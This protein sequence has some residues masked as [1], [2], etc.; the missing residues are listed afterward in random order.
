MLYHTVFDFPDRYQ[1]GAYYLEGSNPRLLRV[2]TNYIERNRETITRVRV[3]LYLL[4]NFELI[5]YL[6][7]LAARG[8]P[9]EI[10]SIPLEGYD[11]RNPMQLISWDA[12]KGKQGCLQAKKSYS[13]L[14][15]A[16]EVYESIEHCEHLIFPHVMIRSPRVRPF[17]RGILPFSLHIKSIL[18]ELGEEWTFFTTS[19]NLAVRDVP[20]HENLLVTKASSEP[21][22]KSCDA[23]YLAL[24]SNSRVPGDWL[25]QARTYSYAVESAL[26]S[27][28]DEAFFTGPFFSGSN[29]KALERILKFIQ[30]SSES[31]WVAAQHISGNPL[32]NEECFLKA[33]L[34]KGRE[35]C[36]LKCLS[37]TYV[38]ENGESHGC[39][40]PMNI[41]SFKSFIGEAKK[42][43]GFHYTAN[44]NLHSKYIVADKQVLVSTFNFTP[45]QFIYRNVSISHFDNIPDVSYE[46]VFSEVGHFT[47]INDSKIV[48]A[49]RANFEK[50]CSLDTSYRAF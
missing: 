3:A 19:S 7:K 43:K 37:Q 44:S 18:V 2:L 46:G 17:S 48:D 8:I 23:F 35:G 31:I 36:E 12:P 34:D 45:S 21:F 11:D 27:N 39:R 26:D 38:D 10:I 5:S 47:I 25:P 13:K 20:K 4:N 40:R 28:C 41:S 49:Y 9:V 14:A 33:L 29:A 42:I 15:A 1:R 22:K 6:E 32:S 30:D 24:S 16:E 50:I